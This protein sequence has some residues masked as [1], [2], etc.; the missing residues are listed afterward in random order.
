MMGIGCTSDV[1]WGQNLKAEAEAKAARP[2]L[3]GR[4]RGQD[5]KDKAEVKNNSEKSTK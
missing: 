5:Y 3:R 4:G 2:E 1:K